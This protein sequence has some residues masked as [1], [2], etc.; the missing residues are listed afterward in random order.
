MSK[1]KVLQNTDK[2]DFEQVKQ[3]KVSEHISI[4]N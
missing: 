4:T 2:F 1:T 3:A